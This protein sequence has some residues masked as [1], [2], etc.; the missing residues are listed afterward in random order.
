M[1]LVLITFLF[2]GY[3]VEEPEPVDIDEM[4]EFSMDSEESASE[5]DSNES[6]SGEEEEEDDESPEN[7]VT[8]QELLVG[9]NVAD[10]DEV[11]DGDWD[12]TRDNPSPKK[13]TKQSKKSLK[14]KNTESNGK[15]AQNGVKN[16]GGLTSLLFSE[17][18]P[19]SDDEGED[20]VPSMK[21]KGNQEK[22]VK[23]KKKG[24]KR[25]FKESKDTE[26][27]AL[28][29]EKSKKAK[30]RTHKVGKSD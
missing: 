20:Y 5:S 6:N 7:P 26:V 3:L 22:S 4:E 18:L 17:S 2:A 9:E 23:L 8:L 27:T 28:K 14:L 16:Q 1:P 29:N 25:K 15:S 30:K 11:S 21:K 12:P 19:S 13:K 24:K 10:D